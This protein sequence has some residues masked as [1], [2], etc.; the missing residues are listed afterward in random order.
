VFSTFDIEVA[1]RTILQEA[2]GETLEGRKAVAHVIKNRLL[3]GRWGHSL[4]SVCLWHAQFS[5]WSCLDPNF[6]YAC[7]V[8]D[9]DPALKSAKDVLNDVLN[10]EEDFTNGAM[11]YYAKTIPAPYWVDESQFCGEWGFQKFYKGTK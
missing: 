3:N 5:G 8:R 9:E 7:G 4:S 6:A 10:G 1:A 11:F 2:R